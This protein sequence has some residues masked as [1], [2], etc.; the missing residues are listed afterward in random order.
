MKRENVARTILDIVIIREPCELSG[1]FV[2]KSNFVA[3]RHEFERTV[4]VS[5]GLSLDGGDVFS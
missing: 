3:R 4:G 5:T 2:C 1:G